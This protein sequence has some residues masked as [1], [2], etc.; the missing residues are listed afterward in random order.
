MEMTSLHNLF[1]KLVQQTMLKQNYEN[2]KLK[3]KKNTKNYKN[4]KMAER[5][6]LIIE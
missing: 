2:N 5:E 1:T 4:Y 6:K 3:K